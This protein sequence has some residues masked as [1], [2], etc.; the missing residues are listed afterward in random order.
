[1]TSDPLWSLGPDV[2]GDQSEGHELT[3]AF[4]CTPYLGF[5]RSLRDRAFGLIAG[6]A[7]PEP[8]HMVGIRQGPTCFVTVAPSVVFRNW[9]GQGDVACLGGSSDVPDELANGDVRTESDPIALRLARQ[10]PRVVFHY[11]STCLPMD[12]PLM[13]TLWAQQEGGLNLEGWDDPIRLN[14]GW[15]KAAEAHL[16]FLPGSCLT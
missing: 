8:L 13:G 12:S 14:A 16:R 2:T 11:S 9:W 4:T 7:F 1:M 10:S 3:I 6:L 15:A 5:W